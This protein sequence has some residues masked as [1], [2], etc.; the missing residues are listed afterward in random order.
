M[1]ETPKTWT[2]EDWAKS[3]AA[4]E[5]AVAAAHDF[6]GSLEAARPRF[7][8]ERGCMEVLM[9]GRLL[10]S[11]PTFRAVLTAEEARDLARWIGEVYPETPK[12]L[13]VVR[14]YEP[15]RTY[16]HHKGCYEPE[17]ESGFCT[18]HEGE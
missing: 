6:R 15:A 12:S 7:P 18:A 4:A 11:G 3:V 13:T 16:C 17:R 14:D 10:V 5:K 1:T 8:L 9:D 2:A